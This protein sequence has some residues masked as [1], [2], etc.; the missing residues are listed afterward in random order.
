MLLI[1]GLPWGVAS[2]KFENRKVEVVTFRLLL[3]P[4][5]MR[6]KQIKK[7]NVVSQRISLYSQEDRHKQIGRHTHRQTDRHTQAD[8]QTDM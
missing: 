5:N 1:F 6:I 4:E 3:A 2:V 7:R 8:R